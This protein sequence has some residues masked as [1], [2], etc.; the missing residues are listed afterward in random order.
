MLT[1]TEFIAT[2]KLPQRWLKRLKPTSNQPATTAP[3]QENE[4]P[5]RLDENGAG[6]PLGE[7]TIKSREYN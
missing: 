1:A 5:A 3:V 2:K 4:Q 6:R 7:T